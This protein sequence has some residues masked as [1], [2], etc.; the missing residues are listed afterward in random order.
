MVAADGLTNTD[1]TNANQNVILLRTDFVTENHS[2]S[3]TK[4]PITNLTKD[5]HY[6][7]SKIKENKET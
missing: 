2:H 5:P 4:Q 1:P 7:L 3:N 6:L